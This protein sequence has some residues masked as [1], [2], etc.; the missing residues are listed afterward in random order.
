MFYALADAIGEAAVNRALA[1]LLA[2]HAFRVR[3]TPPRWI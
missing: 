3:P 2:K 1:A